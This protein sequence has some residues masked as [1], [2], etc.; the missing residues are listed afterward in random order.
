MFPWLLFGLWDGIGCGLVARAVKKIVPGGGKEEEAGEGGT[1]SAD[2][3]GEE[4]VG[5]GGVGVH[6]G[7]DGKDGD[8]AEGVP[9]ADGAGGRRQ[10]VG[11]GGQ[12]GLGDGGEGRG[13][14]DTVFRGGLPDA[15]VSRTD[16]CTDPCQNANA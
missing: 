11:D 5:E 2:E 9:G 16:C 7:I 14:T 4:G 12:A 6:A 13:G 1:M 15:F 3:V 10:H 8:E